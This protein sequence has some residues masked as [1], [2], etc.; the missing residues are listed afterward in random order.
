MS[1][2]AFLAGGA[3]VLGWLVYTIIAW[4]KRQP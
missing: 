4:S 2:A 1:A 3:I